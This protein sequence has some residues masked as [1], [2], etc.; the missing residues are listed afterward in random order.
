MWVLLA[1][2]V[3]S[4]AVLFVVG[5]VAWSG[6]A[7]APSTPEVIHVIAATPGMDVEDA[8]RDVALPLFEAVRG[9]PG[10][11]HVRSEA[12]EGE[13][14]LSLSIAPGTE[15]DGVMSVLRTR[16]EGSAL[17]EPPILRFGHDSAP[18]RWVTAPLERSAVLLEN[19]VR[20]RLEAMPGVAAVRVCGVR[21]ETIEVRLDEVRLSAFDVSASDV[22]RAITTSSPQLP[23]GR[24]VV[25]VRAP[26]GGVDTWAELV[27]ADR[28]GAPVRL[29]DVAEVVRGVRVPECTALRDGQPVVSLAVVL[30]RGL[31]DP[32]PVLAELDARLAALATEHALTTLPSE[33]MAVGRVRALGSREDRLR[34]ASAVAQDVGALVELDDEGLRLI[35]PV[36]EA[37]LV[38]AV[39]AVPGLAYEGDVI[40]VVRGELEAARAAARE[41]REAWARAGHAA[42]VCEDE[43]QPETRVVLDRA[44]AAELGVSA[45]DVAQAV[46]LA[47]AEGLEAATSVDGELELPVV[48]RLGAD[49]DRVRV[50]SRGG[51]IPLTAV[52]R[53]EQSSTPSHLVRHDG[54]PSVEVSAAGEGARDAF[55]RIARDLR[56]P[57]GISIALAPE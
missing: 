2:S 12:R 33:G 39:T 9:T 48:V 57:A 40:A 15:R 20:R 24:L 42:A 22:V 10:V 41:L 31:A 30:Q 50:P 5:F 54:V 19:D 17:P 53:L 49:L 27:I 16:L 11:T 44:R 4:A 52:A 14:V 36:S 21:R 56:S 3:L 29:R 37:A 23:S 26:I 34:L 28:A 25:P 38:A 6:V 46:R 47:S 43:P 55:E 32:R 51:A 18:V 35:A 1:G 13:V 7:E 45:G 8:D